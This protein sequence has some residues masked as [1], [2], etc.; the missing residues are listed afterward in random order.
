[1]SYKS[2]LVQV[3]HTKACPARIDAAIDFALRH[4]AHLT[5]LFLIV[6]P[7]GVGYVRGWLPPEVVE[8][9]IAEAEAGAKEVLA[10]FTA[11]AER[12]QVPCDTRIDR[13]FD[14]ELSD[15]F[16]LHARYADLA[17]LGQED[18]DEPL[19][20]QQPGP[21]VVGCGR[22]V[23]LIPYIGAGEAFGQRVVVAWDA[24]REAARAVCDALP[25]LEKA[26]SVQVV[27]V[28]PRPVDFGHGDVPGA[29]IALYLSRHGVQVDVQQ[30][31]TRDLGVGNALLSHVA[32]E[33]A[34]LLVM[35]GYGHSRLREIVLG[36]AT[37]TILHDMTVPVLMAH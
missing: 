27:S 34:D 32:A 28:N 5:G 6:E 16:A 14:V 1:L 36:G 3:D 20:G 22:P 12:N 4:E 18:P 24:G 17:I 2:I 37:R 23:L 7:T 10:R 9:A 33:G 25:I 13:G 31:E 35:G 19:P 15:I 11:A 26:A 8:A 21:V 30:I 29:D